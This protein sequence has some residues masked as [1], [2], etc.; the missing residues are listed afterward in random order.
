MS[1]WNGRQAEAI[2][3]EEPELEAAHSKSSYLNF[4]PL[5]ASP[6]ELGGIL[7]KFFINFLGLSDETLIQY[8]KT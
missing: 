7:R 4:A 5:A 2:H 1:G 6:V 8:F 3:L